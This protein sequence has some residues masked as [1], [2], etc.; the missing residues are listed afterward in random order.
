[1]VRKKIP[2]SY[3]VNLRQVFIGQTFHILMTTSGMQRNREL[4]RFNVR[5]LD[6]TIPM[7]I[8]Q[9]MRMTCIIFILAKQSNLKTNP[10]HTTNDQWKHSTIHYM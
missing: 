2:N 4:K 8:F 1:M 7:K 5:L 3:Q 6:L 9:C 10:I